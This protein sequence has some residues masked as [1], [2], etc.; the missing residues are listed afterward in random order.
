MTE[1]RP[2]GSWWKFLVGGLVVVACV[3]AALGKREAEP[4]APR[5]LC[6]GCD[7][8]ILEAV[9]AVAPCPFEKAPGYDRPKRESCPALAAWE[10]SFKERRRGTAQARAFALSMRELLNDPERAVRWV[11]ASSAFGLQLPE[12]AGIEGTFVEKGLA[13]RDDSV[14]YELGKRVGAFA[15]MGRAGFEPFVEKAAAAMRA[16]GHLAFRSG[17]VEG[18]LFTSDATAVFLQAMADVATKGDEDEALR[19]AV[20]HRARLVLSNDAKARRTACK[21][22]SDLA[23]TPRPAVVTAARAG[24]ASCV[25]AE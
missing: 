3:V 16:P 9:R 5:P 24:L 18:W 17:V 21:L 13:E 7:R 19:V 23:A 20:I 6:E 2:I 1:R 25:R 10:D 11:A 12:L 8:E 4:P 14:A 22:F 15:S